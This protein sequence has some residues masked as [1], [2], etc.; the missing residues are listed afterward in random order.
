MW[1]PL[2]AGL[3]SSLHCFDLRYA[4]HLRDFKLNLDSRRLWDGRLVL[5]DEVG[6]VWFFDIKVERFPNDVEFQ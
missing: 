3:V 4:A 1:G 6:F 5:K 2:C